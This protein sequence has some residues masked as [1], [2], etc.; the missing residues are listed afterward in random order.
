MAILT[1]P[2]GPTGADAFCDLLHRK[3]QPLWVP[4]QI[5]RVDNGLALELKDG[6]FSVRIGEVKTMAAGGQGGQAGNVRGVVFELVYLGDEDDE[7]ND[8]G[9]EEDERNGQPG[10]SEG[11]AELQSVQD[12]G[13]DKMETDTDDHIKP[14][15]AVTTGEADTQS[16]VQNKDKGDQSWSRRI[17]LMD[18]LFRAL[19]RDCAGL[20][21]ETMRVVCRPPLPAKDGSRIAGTTEE[22]L[23]LVR[24]YMELLRFARPGV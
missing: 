21:L 24:Q 15:A 22:D 13:E 4:W 1:T 8:D 6:M 23:L 16:T 17:A 20:D 11:A 2:T 10:M 3:M 19:F 14:Q 18:S 7:D 12:R 5:V 9:D